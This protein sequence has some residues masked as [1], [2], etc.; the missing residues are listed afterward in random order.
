MEHRAVLQLKTEAWLALTNSAGQR[1]LKECSTPTNGSF[2]QQ[3]ISHDFFFVQ[4]QLC[5][6]SPFKFYTSTAQCI[7]EEQEIQQTV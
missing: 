4:L 3:D 5:K 1:I 2:S 6:I 7:I